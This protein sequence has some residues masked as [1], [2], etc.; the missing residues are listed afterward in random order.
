MFLPETSGSTPGKLA[1]EAEGD[2]VFMT[3]LQRFNALNR[4]VSPNLSPTYAPTVFA[5]QPEAKDAKL[6]KGDWKTP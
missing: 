1:R 3:I 5:G 2:E 6:T 4:P